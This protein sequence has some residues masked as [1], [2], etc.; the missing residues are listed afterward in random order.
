MN[1]PNLVRSDKKS[2]QELSSGASVELPWFFR[3][4]P[5]KG[6]IVSDTAQ[7]ISLWPPRSR[8][9]KRLDSG[10]C[11]KM[12]YSHLFSECCHMTCA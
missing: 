12:Q 4:G 2:R 9:A 1:I 3:S 6:R 11:V 5:K 10:A 7:S 8:G